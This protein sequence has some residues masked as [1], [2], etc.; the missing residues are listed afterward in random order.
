M[1]ESIYSHHEENCGC[2]KCNEKSTKS[3][4][5][6]LQALKTWSKIMTFKCQN[7][8]K[9]FKLDENDLLAERLRKAAPLVCSD[10]CLYEKCTDLKITNAYDM[11]ESTRKTL[12][13]SM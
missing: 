10:D 4:D 3:R 6:A 2:G 5:R 8:K 13:L 12:G 7:C 1:A 9:E 11:I